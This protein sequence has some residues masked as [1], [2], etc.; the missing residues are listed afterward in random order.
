[1]G[2]HHVVLRCLWRAS[3]K[4]DTFVKLALTLRA[5]L[6][7]LGIGAAALQVATAASADATEQ[8]VRERINASVRQID[9]GL[10]V[11]DVAK[12]PIPGM[13]E[14]VINGQVFYFSEDGRYMLQGELVDLQQR[15]SLTEQ[16]RAGLRAALLAEVAK[17]DML[18]YP[19]TGKPKHIVTVVTDIDCPYCRRLHQHMQEMNS[20]GIE[21]RYLLMPRAGIQSESYRK[22]VSVWC[23][24]KPLE[25]MTAAKQGKT[26]ADRQCDNP[27]RQHM[28][29]AER[30]GIN[31]TPTIITQSGAVIAG[32]M[33]P[34]QLL[35]R[36]AELEP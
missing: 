19:A 31:A 7:G 33:P 5:C 36:L 29:L 11:G 3:R 25:A 28:V 9:P 2:R 22:A 26:V 30:M 34:E 6:F 27:V 1:V 20:R 24:D 8:A 17:Q 12:T 16:R 10:Q 14:A 15:V 4:K 32:Y 23:A 21:V 18:I 35:A 13:R